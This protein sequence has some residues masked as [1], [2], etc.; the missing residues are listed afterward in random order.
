MPEPGQS[1]IYP[2]PS[3]LAAYA[4]AD[5]TFVRLHRW[6]ETKIIQTKDGPKVMKLGKAPI[7]KGWTKE[8]IP[9]D[10]AI[11][12]MNTG[13][14]IGAL[15]PAGWAVID[16]DPRNFPV[17]RQVLR[18]FQERTQFAVG[19]L[20]TVVT[21]AG[22]RHFFVR[23]P[24]DF[25]GS[26]HNPDFKGIEFKQIGSQVVSAGSI[27]PDTRKHYQW[28]NGPVA[29]EDAPLAPE[30]VLAL[31]RIIAPAGAGNSNA[32]GSWASLTED[33]II[34]GLAKLD[35]T[36]FRDQDEWFGLMCSIHWL[37]GGQGVQNFIDWS[38]SDPSYA[39]HDEIITMR[40]D[41]LS[42]GADS[43]Q[44]VAKGGLFFKA[45]KTVGVNPADSE[46]QLQVEKDFPDYDDE[47]AK[48]DTAR[49][50]LQ[51][52]AQLDKAVKTEGGMIA[53]LNDR[54]FVLDHKGK[55]VVGR[56]RKDED[57]HGAE[58]T[59][60]SF[61]DVG[62]FKNYYANQFM[63]VT[64]SDPIPIAEWW[65]HHPSRLTYSKMEF[66]PDRPA[67][68]YRDNE[69]LVLN[70]WTGWAI[71]PKPGDWSLFRELL[72]NTICH[73]DVRKF[74]YMLNWFAAAYQQL[75]G[76]IGTAICI[77]GLKGTG[78]T[79]VWEVFSAPFGS[80]HAMSTSRM[81][82]LFG[83][84]NGRMM[85]K[86]ALL[87]EEALFAASKAANN[88][89]KDWITGSKVA[90]NEKFLP[91]Y[92][93]RNYMRIMIFTNSDHIV[94]ATEDE[95]RFFITKALANRKGDEEFWRALRVQ[96]FE[97]GGNAAFFHDMLERKIPDF[98][99][100]F[101]CPIT[102]ELSEQIGM[103]RGAVVDWLMEKFDFGQTQFTYTWNN[104]RGEFVLPINEMYMDFG[105]WQS[106]KAKGR[107]DNPIRSQS[108]F[109]RELKRVFPS[110]DLTTASVPEDMTMEIKAFE[111]I[112]K[113][114]TYHIAKVYKF[115]NFED[116]YYQF[117]SKYGLEAAAY[118]PSN[119]EDDADFGE[120]T[121]EWDIA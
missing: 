53:S 36:N 14:N 116:F 6:S 77:N 105:H 99:A 10:A 94:E 83:D 8:G 112:V 74:E 37:S 60:Y 87:I 107:F 120:V 95:R 84:F 45:L 38:T 30:A 90:I 71:K 69:G 63:K 33:Q 16:V 96:M 29:L 75:D 118:D 81:E 61:S 104:P 1:V 68:S 15:I 47:E 3:N 88:I 110:L 82:E 22:G 85:G 98:D 7:G 34:A 31:F 46:W 55:T 70:Q 121:D 100:Q 109:S 32:A 20:P 89:L 43:N 93:Q 86:A 12:H 28:T 54:H 57:D 56:I 58:I 48:E 19:S 73:G 64:G 49:I 78:K 92:T 103:T 91:A 62:S 119:D 4:K 66:R 13:K 97:Q 50:Q 67:G 17:G 18:E 114:K 113:N 79:T 2:Q 59:V 101:D 117:A 42:R 52:Q 39:D 23:I 25:K 108:A 115:R 26:V 76:P 111:Q 106:G 44:L 24:S 40:W 27:H 72:F 5:W 9:L 11:A 41:S 102:R 80:S 65:F 21:G 35:P 51:N